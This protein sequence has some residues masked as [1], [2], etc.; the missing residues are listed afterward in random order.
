M[1]WL[2]AEKCCVSCWLSVAKLSHGGQPEVDIST[3][4]PS[5]LSR[6]IDAKRFPSNRCRFPGAFAGNPHG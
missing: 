4:M 1:P 6:H 3:A 2:D 5:F